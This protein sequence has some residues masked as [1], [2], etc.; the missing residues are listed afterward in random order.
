MSETE[1]TDYFTSQIYWVGTP[2]NIVFYNLN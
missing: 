1:I 2:I